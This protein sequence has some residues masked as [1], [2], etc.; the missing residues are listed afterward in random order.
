MPISKL[1]IPHAF[2]ALVCFSSFVQAQPPIA[3]GR[4]ATHARMVSAVNVRLRRGP[5]F[6]APEDSLVRLGTVVVVNHAKQPRDTSWVHVEL[7]IT[8]TPGYIH[9]SMLRRIQQRNGP[10]MAEEIAAER[11]A[12]RGDPYEWQEQLYEMLTHQRAMPT[13]SERMGRIALLWMQ[14]FRSML[15][16]IPR[17]EHAREPYRSWFMARVHEGFI[18]LDES[19]GTWR[20][21]SEPLFAVHDLHRETRSG[22]EIAWTVRQMGVR[23][24]CA[25][26]VTCSVASLDSLDAEYLRRNPQGLHAIEALGRIRTVAL[27]SVDAPAGDGTFDAT[28]DCE[29]LVASLASARAAVAGTT[30]APRAGFR[31]VPAS[32]ITGTLAALDQLARRCK[33]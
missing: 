16:S 32:V 11:L 26:R 7:T 1:A 15:G 30:V 31:G 8:G 20:I 23:H 3:P 24:D 21:A 14:S 18:N 10:A 17:G 28:R 22:D 29:M 27:R 33:A 9:S 6:D 4:L 19:A 25:G 13:D 12:R 5:S 2:I